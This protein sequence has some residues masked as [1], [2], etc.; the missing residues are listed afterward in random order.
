MYNCNDVRP[1]QSHA[2]FNVFET[3][4]AECKKRL[5]AAGF[6]ELQMTDSW[7]VD[8][9]GKVTKTKLEDNYQ[10]I[11]QC[12]GDCETL[13]LQVDDFSVDISLL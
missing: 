10:H 1:L 7:R 4:V 5:I 6:S 8:P 3:V 12:A 13:S 11:M 9:S 2:S